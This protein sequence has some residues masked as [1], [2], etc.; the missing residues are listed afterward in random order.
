MPPCNA[1]NSDC[2]TLRPAQHLPTSS[3]SAEEQVGQGQLDG[4]KRPRQLMRLVTATTRESL[5]SHESLIKPKCIYSMICVM[6][7]GNG[8]EP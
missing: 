1:V 5:E 8:F 7:W 2:I 3:L 6:C 4:L